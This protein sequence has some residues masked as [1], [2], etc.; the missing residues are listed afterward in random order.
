MEEK[1]LQR[2][3]TQEF[4]FKSDKSPP[5]TISKV[6]NNPFADFKID[7][8]ESGRNAVHEPIEELEE[9]KFQRKQTQLTKNIVAIRGMRDQSEEGDGTL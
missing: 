1:K 5:Q 6:D 7:Q 4:E 8:L 9:P 3:V 2:E